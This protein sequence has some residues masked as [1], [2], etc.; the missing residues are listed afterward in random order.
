MLINNDE[1][2]KRLSNPMN[3][4]N[5]MNSLSGAE[6][7]KNAMSLFVPSFSKEEQKKDLVSD[8][9]QEPAEFNPFTKPAVIIPEIVNDEASPSSEDL[10]DDVDTKI[11]LQT[12]H[13][14][15][16]KLLNDAVSMLALKLDNVKADKLPSVIASASKV[17]ESIRK[18]RTERNK[19]GKDKTTHLHFYC[20]EPRKI[21]SYEI[22]EVAS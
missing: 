13:D 5:R 17:V 4:M 7:K 12:A 18:E 3:L 10:I 15:S 2:E 9:K 20:P 14:T 11:A 19:D 8:S 21:E 6:R 16:I 22:V 1:A